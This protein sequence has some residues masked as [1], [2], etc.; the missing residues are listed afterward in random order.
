MKTMLS[1][2]VALSV[3]AGIAGSANAFDSKFFAL[4]TKSFWE[5]ERQSY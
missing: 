5:Q 4:G 3:L 1:A 2:L